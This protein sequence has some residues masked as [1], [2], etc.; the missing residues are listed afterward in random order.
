[1]TQAR[2]DEL[3]RARDYPYE[4][5]DASYVLFEGEALDLTHYKVDDL[6]QR[7]AVLA[8][9]SNAAPSQLKRKFAATL[10]DEMVPVLKAFLPGFD[11]VFSARLSRYGAIP[12]TL[13]PSKGTVLETFVTCLTDGQLAKMHE[14]EIDTGKR[15][16]YRY[17]VLSG[18]RMLVDR[19]G[20]LEKVHLYHYA[21][22]LAQDERPFAY[23]GIKAEGRELL[24]LSHVQALA[25]LHGAGDEAGLNASI[26]NGIDDAE[27]RSKQTERLREDAILVRLP[28][29]KKI[30]P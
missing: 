13:A 27:A 24:A 3:A 19:I 15:G 8:Y 2:A 30:L 17:G 26:L 18:V 9:G 21:H 23:E 20:L 10:K 14:T 16:G 29:F 6:D 22:A 5:P 7:T 1:M 25:D 28:R 4:V 11:V 12:A